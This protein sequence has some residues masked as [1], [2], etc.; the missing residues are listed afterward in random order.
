M[1]LVVVKQVKRNILHITPGLPT[2]GAERAL[3]RLIESSQGKQFDHHVIS[4][5]DQGT[6][7]QIMESFGAHVHQV[8]IK[9]FFS[10]P[11]GIRKL[12]KLVRQI[13]P[14]I[15]HGYM[16][17]GGLFSLIAGTKA[18][19]I[20]G[21]RHSLHDLKKDKVT[22]RWLIYLLARFSKKFKAIVYNSAASKE[23]H[24][25]IGYSQKSSWHIP[26]G[27]NTD[28]FTPSSQKRSAT[29]KALGIL[30]PCFVFGN[31]GRNH[32]VKN[33]AG[34]LNAFTRLTKLKPESML[35]LVGHEMTTSNP[36]L[37][38]RIQK[39]AIKDKLLLLGE[40]QDIPELLQAMDC[41]VSASHAEAFPNV[42]GEAMAAGIP[43]IATDVGDSAFIVGDTG[44]VV[45]PNDSEAL[46]N[47]MTRMA[48]LSADDRK[49]LG[50]R[51]R[52]RIQDHFPIEKSTKVYEALFLQ[53]H[54]KR[55]KS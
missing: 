25:N 17:H 1:T 2:G 10:L 22:T 45:L 9:G 23:Q 31:I 29:R 11:C 16:Y 46:T 42:I 51:A 14:D 18:P 47:A 39:F 6:Q 30:E 13:Q 40:R 52:K 41:Y 32:P 19:K 5:T 28:T 33:H 54:E 35:V 20:L 7:G 53:L 26:N 50:K 48:V 49:A 12:R 27:F 8:D 44:I 21:V 34:L 3:V 15:I 4:L 55:Q 38:S 43:C 37:A 24:E 36:V